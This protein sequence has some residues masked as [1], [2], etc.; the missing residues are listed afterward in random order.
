MEFMVSKLSDSDNF[1]LVFGDSFISTSVG[2]CI[3]IC[4][5]SMTGLVSA[6]CCCA[7]KK[8]TGV[9]YTIRLK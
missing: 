1:V 8:K 5:M 7:E 3:G 4:D 6:V 2:S 9:L